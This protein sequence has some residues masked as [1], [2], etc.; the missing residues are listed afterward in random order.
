MLEG[1]EEEKRSKEAI[2]IM[3]EPPETSEQGIFWKKMLQP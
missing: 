3:E 2:W 1:W